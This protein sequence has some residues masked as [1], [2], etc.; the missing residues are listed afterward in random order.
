[1]VC[2]SSKCGFTY[3]GNPTPV[4]AAIIELEGE[5]I[6]VRAHGWPEKVY[7]LVTGFL[8]PV[9]HPEDA[10]CR[11][12][13][14]ELSLQVDELTWIGPYAFAQ[15]NQILLCWHARCSGAIVLSDEIAETKRISWEKIRPW[16]FGTGLA[17]KDW[18]EQRKAH[19]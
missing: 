6:L 18:I 16:P 12:I 9:E 15:Q 11:E 17:V 14:E 10:I 19:L 2:I 13:G 8:E 7:G 3:W 5:I 4:V 1:M